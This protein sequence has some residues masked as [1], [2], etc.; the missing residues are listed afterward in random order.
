MSPPQS[1]VKGGQCLACGRPIGREIGL[2]LM[3]F[4]AAL[5][6]Y[7]PA[8]PDERRDAVPR[9]ATRGAGATASSS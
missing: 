2:L 7:H 4:G 9:Q 6:Q 1:T 8:A 5:Q 3:R